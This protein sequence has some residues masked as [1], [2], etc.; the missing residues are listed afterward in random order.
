VGA[1]LLLLRP[2]RSCYSLVRLSLILLEL[3]YLVVDDLSV[4]LVVWIALRVEG[5]L[6]RCNCLWIQGLHL[7]LIGEYFLALNLN[8]LITFLLNAMAALA[9]TLG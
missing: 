2:L 8:G 3:N 6:D 1:L 4:V 7:L 9:K 5:L